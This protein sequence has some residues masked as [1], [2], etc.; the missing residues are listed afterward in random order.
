MVR[1]AM[2]TRPLGQ[3]SLSAPGLVLNLAEQVMPERSAWMLEA[4]AGWLSQGPMPLPCTELASSH[5]WSVLFV[6]VVVF[7]LISDSLQALEDDL[8]I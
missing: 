6:A 5:T 4:Y 3:P 2:E 8:R 1:N 7:L